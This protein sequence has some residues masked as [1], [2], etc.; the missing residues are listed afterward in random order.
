MSI[1]PLTEDTLSPYCGIGLIGK[2]VTCNVRNLDNYL[3]GFVI[4]ITY[5]CLRC[6]TIVRLEVRDFS[7]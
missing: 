2:I 7:L 5:I 4:I 6:Q 1:C 3:E